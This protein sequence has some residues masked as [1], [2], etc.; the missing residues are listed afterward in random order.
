MYQR[1]S[2]LAY[3]TTPVSKVWFR[4]INCHLQSSATQKIHGTRLNTQLYDSFSRQ[5][6]SKVNTP[7]R[8]CSFRDT[9]NLC[10]KRWKGN[11]N[12]KSER[13][14]RFMPRL[15]PQH[16]SS[17][18]QESI[19]QRLQNFIFRLIKLTKSIVTHNHHQVVIHQNIPKNHAYENNVKKK[20]T[21]KYDNYLTKRNMY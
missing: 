12:Q 13:M 4:S 1:N 3:I 9:S 19:L 6:K 14:S 18:E 20:K 15:H 17:S 8:T 10:H 7:L 5:K 21:F 16:S 2:H 11:Y